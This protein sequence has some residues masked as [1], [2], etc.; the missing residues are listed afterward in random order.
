MDPGAAEPG[1]LSWSS[2][3]L[4]FCP[5]KTFP[6]SNP[7]LASRL[8]AFASSQ[9]PFAPIAFMAEKCGAEKYLQG[10]WRSLHKMRKCLELKLTKSR[11]NIRS[12]AAS[13]T[14]IFYRFF[15]HFAPFRGQPLSV[16][17][18]FVAQ[19]GERRL[20]PCKGSGAIKKTRPSDRLGVYSA[21][22]G[23]W[24]FLCASYPGR[25]PSRTRGLPWAVL[26]PRRWR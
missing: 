23:L 8:S 7:L 20:R 17:P 14:T 10:E 16:G 26:S 24:I 22:L 3:V 5:S 1:T 13:L 15:V 4:F 25:R 2:F 19:S 18:H 11:I 6:H 9:A 21:P 12:I